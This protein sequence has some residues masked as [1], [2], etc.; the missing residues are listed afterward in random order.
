M[1]KQRTCFCCGK[2]Y[3]YCPVCDGDKNKPSWYFIFDSDNCRKIFDTCQ[4]FSTK[5]YTADEA[6]AKLD[7]C[8]LTDKL[9][10]FLTSKMSLKRSSPRPTKRLNPLL[11]LL[12]LLLRRNGDG[13]AD[14]LV[15]RNNH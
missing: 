1:G 10:F 2:A 8:D 14:L 13:L 11:L 3:H 6:R 5:E 12:L 7:K 15:K 4:R 9:T